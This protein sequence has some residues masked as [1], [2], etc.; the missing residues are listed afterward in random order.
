MT[1][2]SIN[3][4]ITFESGSYQDLFLIIKVSFP[5]QPLFSFGG[6]C[7]CFQLLA[8]CLHTLVYGCGHSTTVRKHYSVS[9][10]TECGSISRACGCV[11]IYVYNIHYYTCMC[12]C[13][14]HHMV[15]IV[16]KS[17]QYV[18][19]LV[20]VCMLNVL[21]L[22]TLFLSLYCT[23]ATSFTAWIKHSILFYSI[24]FY[25]NSWG[26]FRFDGLSGRY[27]AI[28]TFVN[29]NWTCGCYFQTSVKRRRHNSFTWNYLFPFLLPVSV[30]RQFLP[31]LSS[32]IFRPLL[33]S[34]TASKLMFTRWNGRLHDYISWCYW[35]HASH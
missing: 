28:V 9:W 20:L 22:F 24:L 15:T 19:L 3:H 7:F 17:S 10:L 2:T 13:C 30:S 35:G 4:P 18:K 25:S 11:Y 32:I 5:H 29:C 6:R 21:Y 12:I 34:V 31:T 26:L 14:V 8:L 23:T 1:D 33:S 27:R 16:T